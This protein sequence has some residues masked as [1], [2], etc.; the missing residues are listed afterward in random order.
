MPTSDLQE[1]VDSPVETLQ[2]EYKEWIDISSDHEARASTARHIS[3]LANY[4]G[5]FIVFGFR[6]SDLA[7]TGASPFP[8]Y[9]HDMI[10]SI[11]KHYLEPSVHCDVMQVKSNL[12]H[13]HAVVV[14]P[15]HAAVP[16]C[17]RAGGPQRDGKVRGIRQGA[18]YLRKTG[19]ESAP[20]VSASEWAA[21]IRRCALHDR[22]SILAALGA[23]LSP[24][25]VAN[26]GAT[27]AQWHTAAN[28]AFEVELRR[29]KGPQF[30]GTNNALFSY[31]IERS[32][33]QVLELSSFR[34]EVRRM[35][36]DIRDRVN[37]GWSMFYPFDNPPI[38]AHFEI[39][40]G[41]GLGNEEFLECCII[42]DGGEPSYSDLWR[43]SPRG[44][45]S[46][47]RP[48]RGDDFMRSPPSDW[49]PRTWFN[50]SD[51]AREVG[52]F[53]RHAQA[54]SERFDSPT[55][56]T[57]RCEWVGLKGR[58][59]HD[60]YGLWSPGRIAQ[61]DSRLVERTYSLPTIQGQWP[62]I[63]ADLVAPVM[64]AFSS[65]VSLDAEWIKEQ[66]SKWRPMGNHYP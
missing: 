43:L 27:L 47:Q 37:T 60:R 29:H 18:Y 25:K 31:V 50:P 16:I 22:A 48:F 6:D 33:D 62:Q 56:V 7:P 40:P 51:L 35:N 44:L 34:E 12:G 11:S 32:D 41:S 66:A 54:F 38:A 49:S 13:T 63:V 9:T 30:V 8:T 42:R 15:S 55:Q 36:I 10:A 21:V 52:E 26:N 1:L 17:A 5:G 3:A 61:S 45:A 14:V 46:I 53:V 20:I 58:E 4:G 64:R 39:D 19:P 23:A 2:C 28:A 57:F 65:A 59:I 24:A